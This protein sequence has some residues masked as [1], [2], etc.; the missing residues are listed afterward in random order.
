MKIAIVYKSVTGNT[1]KI[2]EVIKN[3][4]KLNDI[5]YFGEL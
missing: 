2:A 3:E 1:Q 4:I 5:V